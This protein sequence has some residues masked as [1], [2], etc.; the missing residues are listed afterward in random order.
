VGLKDL[1]GLVLGLE[2]G[3]L[4][5]GFEE[6]ALVLGFEDGALVL[7]FEEGELVVLGIDDGAGD[8]VGISVGA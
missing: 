8:K 4:V 3:A 5:L 6:G 1:D 2:E 7:G